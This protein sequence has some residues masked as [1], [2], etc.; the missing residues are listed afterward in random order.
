MRG[1][2]PFSASYAVDRM[3]TCTFNCW[4][5]EVDPLFE[6]ASSSPL[7]RISASLSI[8]FFSIVP[9][10]CVIPNT[11]NFHCAI[12]IKT[13]VLPCAFP[14]FFFFLFCLFFFF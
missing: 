14:I 8:V 4:N 5:K 12:E 11:R 9:S 1:A 10:F 7:G 3:Y 6:D 13:T 2:F